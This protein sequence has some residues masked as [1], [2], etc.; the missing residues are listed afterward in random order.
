MKVRKALSLL[1]LLVLASTLIHSA[2]AAPPGQGGDREEAESRMREMLRDYNSFLQLVDQGKG[3]TKEAQQTFA[4]YDSARIRFCD[5]VAAPRMV[6]EAD[7]ETRKAWEEYQRRRAEGRLD[8]VHGVGE[9]APVSIS[10]ILGLLSDGEDTI[11]STH[12]AFC[13]TTPPPGYGLIGGAIQDSDGDGVPD[14]IDQCRGT[15]AGVAV[16]EKGCRVE[17]ARTETP[18]PKA[19]LGKTPSLTTTSPDAAAKGPAEAIGDLLSGYSLNVPQSIAQLTGE[20]PSIGANLGLGTDIN[21]PG[22]IRKTLDWGQKTVSDIYTGIDL[23][24]T[25]ASFTPYG[26]V[27]GK[28]A[29]GIKGAGQPLKDL[30]D[31]KKNYNDSLKTLNQD[32]RF[33]SMSDDEKG[34]RAEIMAEIKSK[35]SKVLG[36]A[37]P[38]VGS[39]DAIM[40][41][42]S[43][44]QPEYS[45]VTMDH[46][47]GGQKIA[48]DT[49]FSHW[50]S[51]HVINSAVDHGSTSTW[52]DLGGVVQTQW[53]D[54]RDAEGVL[55]KAA[56]VGKAAAVTTYATGVAVAK[57]AVDGASFVADKAY[58]AWQGLKGLF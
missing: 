20:M 19:A 57:V 38:S 56:H 21:D 25:I 17:A 30:L 15:L 6:D 47:V 3:G 1:L 43:L 37:V 41:G 46:D 5:C 48:I 7:E 16:D 31:K 55:A 33:Q 45:K 4:A 52:Q 51:G 36:D 18:R 58:K 35:V 40:T 12:V 9:P 23:V 34:I 44:I 29:D 2:Q 49:D 11:E 54:V 10:E 27:V 53:T 32:P 24:N 22:Q 14:D 28:V 8:E 50:T 39:A 26:K 42:L 13:L